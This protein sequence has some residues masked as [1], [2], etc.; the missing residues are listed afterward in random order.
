MLKG[1]GCDLAPKKSLRVGSRTFEPMQGFSA[2]ALLT[3]GAQ[4]S[5]AEGLS[6][7]VFSGIP[8]RCPLNA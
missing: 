2:S 7:R 4:L 3:L 5:V 8:G 1:Q 6:C